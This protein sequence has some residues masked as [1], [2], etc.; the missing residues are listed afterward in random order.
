MELNASQLTEALRDI[1]L[2]AGA[3]IMSVY[4]GDFEARTKADS[5]PVTEADEVAERLIIAALEKLTPEIPIV[6]EES[7]S[8]GR[9]PDISGGRFWLVDPLDGTK[10]FISRNGEFTVNVALVEAGRPVLGIVHAP[11][12]GVTY[13]AADGAAFVETGDEP[14]RRIHARRPAA[15]GVVALISR[16]HRTPETDA[17]LADYEVT[18]ER[19]AGSSLKFGIVAGGEAD[20]YPRLGRTMEWDTAAG[21]A[22]VASAGGSVRTLDGAEL[23]YG[24]PGFENPPFV[25]RGLDD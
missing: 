6:A 9:I 15:D 4:Q 20:I 16:S 1:A 23:V 25:V 17:Y 19:S 5:S 3:A 14:A 11:A 18:A 12:V 10:E 24:K 22:V 13:T 7:V 8:A 21:H 2:E